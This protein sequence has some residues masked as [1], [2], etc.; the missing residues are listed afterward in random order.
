MKTFILLL[1]N[2]PA[3]QAAGTDPSRWSSTIRQNLNQHTNFDALQD[4][5]CLKKC[6]YVFFMTGSTILNCLGVTAL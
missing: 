1:L 4:L 6:Q 5:E 2:K 3:A